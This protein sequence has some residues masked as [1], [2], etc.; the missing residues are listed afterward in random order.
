MLI[1]IINHDPKCNWNLGA[2]HLSHFD[3]SLA[4]NLADVHII[5]QFLSAN[6]RFVLNIITKPI[7]YKKRCVFRN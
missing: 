4:N 2:E 5:Q 6:I 7:M 3:I 1:N